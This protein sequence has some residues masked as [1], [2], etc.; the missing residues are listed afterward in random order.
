VTKYADAAGS[1]CTGLCWEIHSLAASLPCYDSSFK[2][3]DIPANGI[4]LF[5]EKGEN[6]SDGTP[7]IVRVGTHVADGRL[8]DRLRNHY[9]G[10]RYSRYSAGTWAGHCCGRKTLPGR[11]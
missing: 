4:Y 8:P 11:R 6:R 3:K 10:N 9:R 7:R 1:C 2:R 5:Y